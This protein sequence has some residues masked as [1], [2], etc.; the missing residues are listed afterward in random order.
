M[1]VGAILFSLKAPAPKLVPFAYAVDR[2]SLTRVRAVPADV[3]VSPGFNQALEGTALARC[4][5][6]LSGHFGYA[7]AGRRHVL[8]GR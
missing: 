3:T 4:I 6:L 5:D 7:A 1:Y 2:L 8:R